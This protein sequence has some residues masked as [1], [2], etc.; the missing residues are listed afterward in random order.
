MNELVTKT[1]D[2][3][4]KN[5]QAYSEQR[6]LVPPVLKRLDYFMEKLKEIGGKEVLD[7]GCGPGRDAQ[8][9]SEH[10]LIVKAIDLSENLISMAKE[11]VRGVDFRVMDMRRLDFENNRF[12]GL[13]IN[14]SFLHI[15]KEE[16]KATLEEFVRVLKKDGL[17]FLGIMAHRNETGVVTTKIADDQMMIATKDFGESDR[18]FVFYSPSEISEMLEEV[19]FE[20]DKI[21]LRKEEDTKIEW[22]NLFARKK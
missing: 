1:I 12:D 18:F 19:G 14:T 20:I 17:I 8:Y 13:W 2:A 15:P 22:I 11:R 5:T 3:Y 16:A 10:G 7:V 4:D 9:L 21:D 6:P